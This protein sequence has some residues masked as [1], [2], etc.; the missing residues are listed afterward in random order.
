MNRQIS[1]KELDAKLEALAQDFGFET[2]QARNSDDLDFTKFPPGACVRCLPPPTKP[3][4]K[5]PTQGSAR[6]RKRWGC[7]KPASAP[8]TDGK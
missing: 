8:S 6:L 7:S 5:M 2:L 3:A 1:E 4:S